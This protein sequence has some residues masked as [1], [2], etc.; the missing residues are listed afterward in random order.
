MSALKRVTM[1]D[2]APRKKN[3]F[4]ALRETQIVDSKPLLPTG[5]FDLQGFPCCLTSNVISNI[6]QKLY[7]QFSTIVRYHA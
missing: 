4:S 6:D 7:L 2:T 5:A 1:T 3:P